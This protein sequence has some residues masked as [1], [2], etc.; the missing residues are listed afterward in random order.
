GENLRG[1]AVA[2]AHRLAGSKRRI[3]Q[4]PVPDG[5]A[6]GIDAATRKALARS[7]GGTAVRHA[8]ESIGNART[9]PVGQALARER[10]IFQQLRTGEEA[11]A[12]RHLF[13]A[14]REAAR[15][16]DSSSDLVIA[17]VGIVGAGTMGSA[18]AVAFA[19][20]GYD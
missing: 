17:K 3:D 7:R 4:Q 9:M 1:E 18:I 16:P 13:F 6:A 10:E 5:D 19:D 20:A 8:L 14:E 2:M 15:V 11:A 12:L